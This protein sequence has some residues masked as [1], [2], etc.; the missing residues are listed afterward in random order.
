MRKLN[1]VSFL[2]LVT[3]GLV[4]WSSPA[5]AYRPF[6]STDPSVADPGEFE[7]EFSPISFSWDDS[8]ET[9][10]APQLKF[11]YGFAPKW[12]LVVRFRA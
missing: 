5:F 12:E 6:D 9:W 11:N 8:H 4:G 10:I 1:D 3:I 7:I 2:A